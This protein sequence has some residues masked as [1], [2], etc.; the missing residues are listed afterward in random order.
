MENRT[1]KIRYIKAVLLFFII[2]LFI[3]AFRFCAGQIYYQRAQYLIN[4]QD[5]NPAINFLKE[6]INWLPWDSSIQHSLGM[7]YLELARRTEGLFQEVHYSIALEHL[8]KAEQLNPL[9]PEIA[10]SVAYTLESQGKSSHEEILAAYRQA[11]A[12]APNAVQYVELLAYKLWEFDHQEELQAVVETL[13]RICPDCYYRI[14]NKT[15]WSPVLEVRFRQGLLQAIAHGN[16]VRRTARMV[17]ANIMAQNG[18]WMA[19]AEQQRLALIF[20]QHNNSSKDYFQLAAYYLHDKKLEAAYEAMLIG[21]A[22]EESASVSLQKLLPIFQQTGQQN[23]FPD[24]Y[25]LLSSKL[26]FSYAEDIQLAELLIQNKQDE[27]ALELLNN[28]IAERDYLPKPWLLLSEIYRRQG[29]VAEM[30]AAD[31]KAKIRMKQAD[32]SLSMPS[33][34]S[35]PEPSPRP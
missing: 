35:A 34:S 27:F 30:E 18:D 17:L 24:F 6:G 9:E 28:V 33:L 11:A 12:L 20:E 3:P 22:K 29:R 31:S 14:R 23:A 32:R 19:A 13:G 10:V 7:T 5:Y 1:G 21:A 8:R 25:R 26:S 16:A 2:L 15:W 4:Q